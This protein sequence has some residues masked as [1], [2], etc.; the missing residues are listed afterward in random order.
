MYIF[1][2]LD[3]NTQTIY[4]LIIRFAASVFIFNKINVTIGIFFIFYFSF[5]IQLRHQLK[6]IA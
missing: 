5:A 4:G 3:D 1:R 6:S 2:S